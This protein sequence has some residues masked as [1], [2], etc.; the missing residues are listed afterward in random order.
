MEEYLSKLSKSFIS[1]LLSSPKRLE[2][3][4]TKYDVSINELT[5]RLEEIE[6]SMTDGYAPANPESDKLDEESDQM[7]EDIFNEDTNN[8]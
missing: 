5:S 2:E 4:A 8:S 3:L 1:V 7:L 6:G